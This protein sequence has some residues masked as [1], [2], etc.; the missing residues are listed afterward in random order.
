ME[1]KSNKSQN[2]IIILCWMVY[3]FAYLGRYSYNANITP[4]MADFN[5]SKADAGLVS[6]CFFFAYAI[7]QVV[8]GIFCRR[9]NK[10]ILFPIVLFGSAVLNA[11]TLFLPFECFKY[12]WTVNG[13]L[14]SMLWSS[15]ISVLSSSLDSRHMSKALVAMSTTS[16]AGTVMTYSAGSL[17]VWLG[18]YRIMFCV[19]AAVMSA[20][21]LLWLALYKN[22]APITAE[23]PG[24]KA[25]KSS[26]RAKA[27]IVILACLAFFGVAD[28]LI[29]DGLNTWVP[30]IL[31]EQYGMKNEVSIL[32]TVALP[33]LGM[34]GA[35]VAV[36][37]NSIITDFVSLTAV[38]YTASALFIGVIVVFDSVS[39]VVM[40]IC[41]G[42]ATLLMHSVNNVI[43]AIAP[44]KLRDS[45]DSGKIAG[46]LNGFCYLG[47][48]VSSYGL[49]AVADVKGWN[50]VFV[51]MFA[52]CIVSM[53]IGFTY[54][55]LANIVKRRDEHEKDK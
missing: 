44:L 8:N 12:L 46:V 14:Q 32:S 24:Q 39:P 29:K 5:I 17:F 38:F 55:L 11:A 51:L 25:E 33:I 53:L 49:G 6:T 36:K 15:I 13:F 18:D 20:T 30:T 37:L 21:A 26:V 48:T 7:G 27:P 10:K 9:Y 54:A 50:A 2:L 19:G 22:S 23:A 43:T 42:I 4:I 31:T 35:V 3:T 41:F 40:M 47:S 28:N 52:F 16:T 1:I 45:V 34:L